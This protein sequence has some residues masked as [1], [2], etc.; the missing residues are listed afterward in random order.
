M[1]LIKCPECGSDVSDKAEK[2]PKCG[3]SIN[4]Q[5][6]KKSRKKMI[7]IISVIIVLLLIAIGCGV[8][9]YLKENTC[10]FGHEWQEATCTE[11]IT[12]S[13]CG[14]TDG[15][16]LGHKWIEAT[17]TEAKTCEVCGVTD[18]KALGHTTRMGY[19]DN[20][21]RYIS[22]L[23]DVY[24]SLLNDLSVAGDKMSEA[25]ETMNLTNSFYD[26][27]YVAQ[28]NQINYETKQLLYAAADE[29]DKYDE[30]SKAAY[31][32]R[33]AAACVYYFDNLTE[34]T[35]FG[36]YEYER[37]MSTS[38]G[39]CAQSLGDAILLLNDLKE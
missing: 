24:V 8:I 38:L 15:Q 37:A 29:A 32:I 16:P 3:V 11:P 34:E 27:H 19:C 17:C 10:V 7:V 23:K 12:C 20:C 6:R 9:W 25:M 18:G 2:C 1:A 35:S 13:K 31:K 22:E 26:T 21:G 36:S 30:F 28:A 39:N 5:I 14:E 4:K 33:D